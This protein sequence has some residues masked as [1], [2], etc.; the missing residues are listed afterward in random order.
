MSL[1]IKFLAGPETKQFLASLE[2]I[3]ERMEKAVAVNGK[4]IKAKVKN[5]KIEDEE[6]ETDEID[7]SDF[8]DDEETEAD[9]QASEMDELEEEDEAPKAK[10]AKASKLSIDD[11]FAAAKAKLSTKGM[12]RDKVK[13]I[14]KKKFGVDSMSELE[15]DQFAAAIKALS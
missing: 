15:S 12:T 14:I 5:A 13:A 1:E 8:S 9:R 11:V 2:K 10:K 4:A 7:M 6:E 3:V